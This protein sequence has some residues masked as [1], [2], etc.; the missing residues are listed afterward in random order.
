MAYRS[1][2]DGFG[3][4]DRSYRRFKGMF[5]A[6]I[7]FMVLAVVGGGIALVAGGYY[8]HHQVTFKVTD[9]E[10]VCSGSNNGSSS[11][12]YL[13]WTTKGVFKDTDSLVNGKFS[14]S[15]LYGMLQPGKTFT[16]TYYGW[17]LRFFSEYPNL[18]SCKPVSA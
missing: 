13:I 11:C 1:S 2:Y 14:S 7:V 9:R 12:K 15:D 16:C 4:F 6:L 8:K 10:R 5:V 18:T 3:N 17:R